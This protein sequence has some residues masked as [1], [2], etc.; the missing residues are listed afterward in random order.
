[1]F[2]QKID[3]FRMMRGVEKHFIDHAQG[4]T[5]LEFDYAHDQSDRI[6]PGRRM[7]SRVQG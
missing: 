5:L 4:G 6:L 1:M 7:Q 2:E 3:G